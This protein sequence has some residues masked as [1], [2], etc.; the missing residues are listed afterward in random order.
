MTALERK[1]QQVKVG[2][3]VTLI[4]RVER[5]TREGIAVKVR[6]GLSVYVS[7]EA[8]EVVK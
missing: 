3:V 2:D 6:D 4:G 5:V 7:P 8:V 1:G